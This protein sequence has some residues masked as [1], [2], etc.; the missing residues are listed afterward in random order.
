MKKKKHHRR[1]TQT[2]SAPLCDISNTFYDLDDIL[3]SGELYYKSTL[4]STKNMVALTHNSLVC[5]KHDK[6][7]SKPILVVPLT[8]YRATFHKRHSRLSYEI[9]LCHNELED[10]SFLTVFKEWAQTWCEVGSFSNFIWVFHDMK[11]FTEINCRY[12]WT[13]HK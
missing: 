2:L 5:Y 9:Q 12:Y 13:S 4:L 6:I 11:W 7:D 10:H 3:L 8:G 1:V